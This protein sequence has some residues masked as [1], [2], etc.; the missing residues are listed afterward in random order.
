MDAAGEHDESK[1]QRLLE[2][3][4]VVQRTHPIILRIALNARKYASLHSG[5]RQ[6][7]GLA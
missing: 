7:I 4:A 6:D 3:D 1:L 5:A 2:Q